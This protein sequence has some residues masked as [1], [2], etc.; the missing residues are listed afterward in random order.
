[1]KSFA[2]ILVFLFAFPLHATPPALSGVV[3][4][5]AGAPVA[6]AE[7]LAVRMHDPRKSEASARADASGRFRIQVKDCGQVVLKAARRDF[8]PSALNVDACQASPDYR[9][10]LRT[11]VTASGRIVAA[12]GRPVE[13]AWIALAQSDASLRDPQEPAPNSARTGRDGRF[14]LPGVV[15][16][17][18]VLRVAHPEHPRL[19]QPGIEVPEGTKVDL[20]GFALSKPQRAEGQVV[21][22]AG[23]PVEGVR[24]LAFFSDRLDIAAA[25]VTGPDGRFMLPEVIVGRLTLCKEGYS[26]YQ[27]PL[28]YPGLFSKPARI[29]LWPAPPPLRVAGRVVDGEGHPVAGARVRSGPHENGCTVFNLIDPCTGRFIPDQ[30]VT[31]DADG[32]FSMEIRA[33][34]ELDIKAEAPGHLPAVQSRVP[35]TQSAGIELVLRR[36]PTVTGRVLARDGSPAAGVRVTEFQNPRSPEAVTDAQGRFRLEG[37]FPG[38]RMLEARHP[39]L[40][41][42]LRRLE[43]SPGASTLDFHLD[44]M[45]ERAVAGR[46][47]DPD[48]NPLPGA[49]VNLGEYFRTWSG[50]DGRFRL[51]LDADWNPPAPA[52]FRVSHDG[53]ASASLA[54]RASEAP[55]RDL[56]IRLGPEQSVTGYLL[57]LEK[58]E[59]FA[60]ATVTAERGT[61]RREVKV[62][63]EGRYRLGGL[64]PGEWTVSAHILGRRRAAARAVLEPGQ[65]E[66]RLDLEAVVLKEEL[67]GVEIRL[68]PGW[69][70]TGRVPGVPAGARASV[71]AEQDG[72]YRSTDAGPDGAYRFDDLGPGEWK[73]TASVYAEG[74][75]HRE[76]TGSVTL[77]HETGSRFDFDL[78]LGDASLSGR[79][80]SDDAPVLGVLQLLSP[81]GNEVDSIYVGPLE[82][83]FRFPHLRPGTYTL[84]ITDRIS[85]RVLSRDVEVSGSEEIAID[86]RNRL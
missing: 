71:R 68:L 47:L 61:E 82:G 36:N 23:R 55:V 60:N 12:D 13:G 33:R 34:V 56:E 46:V 81:E 72:V 86:L 70:L 18:Y 80:G 31:S 25:P 45:P 7:V 32:R 67:D 24:I 66:V 10:V 6:G 64:G 5:E 26:S 43:V 57:G 16:G 50:A 14:T 28:A 44:G 49:Y 62:T 75:H 29:A 22:Q 78:A 21:D 40:G 48:G 17:V 59:D 3:V 54:F 35:A 27:G 77:A 11:G 74:F 63:R 65:E 79:L 53:Y 1:M 58:P 52:T 38:R 19:H 8:A 85:G 20:G 15:P 41:R 39:E 84:R 51:V 83:E 9:I 4:N 37:V 42:A 73:L 30:V 2:A 76:G 69:T